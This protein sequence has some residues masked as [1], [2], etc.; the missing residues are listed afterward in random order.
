MGKRV[1]RLTESDIQKIVERV[2]SEQGMMPLKYKA[3]GAL[4]KA[5][6]FFKKTCR[7]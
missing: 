2:I 1:V 7:I 3:Q 5:S 6:E 4:E